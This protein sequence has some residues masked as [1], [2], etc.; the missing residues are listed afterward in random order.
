MSKRDYL[1]IT[2]LK[3][4][5]YTVKSP[6]QRYGSHFLRLI[7]NAAYLFILLMLV[8]FTLT[9]SVDPQGLVTGIIVSLILS[10]VLSKTYLEFGMPPLGIKRVVLSIVYILI[11]FWEVAKANLDVAYRILHP[12]MPIKPGIVVIK[13]GLK[14]DIAKLF[15]ANSIT[16][17]PGTFTLDIL[18]DK[19][20]IHWINVKAK[21]IN[22][23][24]E[25]IGKKFERYLK[26][27]FE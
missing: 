18:G 27:I 16:L 20:L 23:A 13:T 8:W 9:C 1:R 17:T 22:E 4:F 10:L 15:L 21:S 6:Y 19:L 5:P 26:D 24:T 2:K 7:S 12:K 3:G 14:S 11:L 25:I